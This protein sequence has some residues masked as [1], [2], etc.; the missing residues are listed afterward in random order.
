MYFFLNINHE[1]L[2]R[3]REVQYPWEQV[4]YS[5]ILKHSIEGLFF[6]AWFW[7]GNF[8][9]YGA[10]TEKFPNS[11]AR[12]Q[13]SYIR[14]ASEICLNLMLSTILYLP[15]RLGMG[16]LG[17]NDY[18]VKNLCWLKKMRKFGGYYGKSFAWCN[19]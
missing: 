13:V 19:C 11:R 2:R 12:D 17:D 16:I 6:P 15:W 8:A 3:G 7:P 10:R 5:E 14:A 9:G 4:Q 1:V 18:I